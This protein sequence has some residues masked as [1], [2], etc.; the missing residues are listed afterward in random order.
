MCKINNARLEF[1]AD[2]TMKDPQ[3][4]IFQSK[5]TNFFRLIGPLKGDR[6]LYCRLVFLITIQTSP[7][8]ISWVAAVVCLSNM[9][10]I[11]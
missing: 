10:W 9:A 1:G 2:N 5:M 6:K 3:A 11:K 4:A 8:L 7:L